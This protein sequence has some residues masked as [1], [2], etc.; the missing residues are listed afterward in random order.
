MNKKRLSLIGSIILV[1]I[2]FGLGGF[3]LLQRTYS[4]TVQEVKD[5]FTGTEIFPLVVNKRQI[6]HEKTKRES[7][8]LNT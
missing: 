4:P 1:G 2:L 3:F 6:N 8:D 7:D 5:E